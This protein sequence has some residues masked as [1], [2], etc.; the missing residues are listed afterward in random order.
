MVPLGAINFKRRNKPPFYSE[1]IKKQGKVN[2]LNL[3]N[4]YFRQKTNYNY[5]QL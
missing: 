3:K 1:R 2:S 5:C 4:V